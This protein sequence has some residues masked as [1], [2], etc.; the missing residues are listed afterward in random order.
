MENVYEEIQKKMGKRSIEKSSSSQ[1]QV[2]FTNKNSQGRFCLPCHWYGKHANIFK[3]SGE[4]SSLPEQNA[5]QAGRPALQGEWVAGGNQINHLWVDVS[6]I[7]NHRFNCTCQAFPSLGRLDG[8]QTM[9]RQHRG[10]DWQ[11]GEDPKMMM[12]ETEILII[13]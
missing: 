8:D 6:E 3:G 5:A 10:Q 13:A 11:V 9:P 7:P 2:Q 12:A 4:H 1:A